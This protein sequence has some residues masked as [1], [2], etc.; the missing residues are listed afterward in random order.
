MSNEDRRVLV[1]GATG[2][3][4]GRLVVNLLDAGYAVRVLA[5]HPEKLRD[6]PWADDVEVVTGDADDADA[7]APACEG[8]QVAYF[9]LHSLGAGDS[10]VRTDRRLAEIFAAAAR[11]ADVERIVYLGALGPKDMSRVVLTPCVATGGRRH[12][13]PIRSAHSGTSCGRHH[14]LGLGIVREVALPH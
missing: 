13:S 10:F 3:I 1:T 9:L 12:P 11:M 7:M 14:R 6:R 8:V 4:G 2:Y 5:R